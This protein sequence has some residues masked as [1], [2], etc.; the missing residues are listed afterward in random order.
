MAEA[1]VAVDVHD[2]GG[3]GELEE[4]ELLVKLLRGDR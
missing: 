2:Q 1:V 3:L 4:L